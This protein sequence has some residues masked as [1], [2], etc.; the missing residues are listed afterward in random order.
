MV[1]AAGSGHFLYFLHDPEAKL[2]TSERRTGLL[3]VGVVG[4]PGLCVSAI[5]NEQ[6]KDN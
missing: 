2:S 6:A 4:D 5:R 1:S 3:Q